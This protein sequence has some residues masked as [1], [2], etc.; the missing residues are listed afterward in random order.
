VRAV[1]VFLSVGFICLALAWATLALF[2]V[3]ILPRAEPYSS[4]GAITVVGGHLAAFVAFIS[5]S[6]SGISMIVRH[7][8]DCSLI[9]VS[10]IGG[11][12]ALCALFS[13]YILTPPPVL[14]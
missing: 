9:D 7:R 1:R 12:I 2:I 14:Y 6:I 10:L 5:A 11:A 3:G 13:Y 4:V 8:E